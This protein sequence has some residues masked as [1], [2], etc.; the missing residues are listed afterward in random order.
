M[1]GARG[2]KALRSSALKKSVLTLFSSFFILACLPL[3]LLWTDANA[4]KQAVPTAMQWESEKRDGETQKNEQVC[5][6][7]RQARNAQ[8]AHFPL[9]SDQ[10]K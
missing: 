1:G 4:A 8:N 2:A 9:K 10:A 7:R 5:S 6:Q 3:P